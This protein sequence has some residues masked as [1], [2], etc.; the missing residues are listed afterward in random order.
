MKV[1]IDRDGIAEAVR[2]GIITQEQ[3]EQLWQFWGK[4]QDIQLDGNGLRISKFLYYLGALIVITAMGWYVN[5]SWDSLGGLGLFVIAAVYAVCF[6]LAAH[7]M[8]AKSPVLSG[9]LIVMAVGTT[10]LGVY[11]IQKALGIWPSGYPGYYHDFYIWVK[12]GWFV[13]EF[14]TVAAGVLSLP[15]ARIP[16]AMAPVAFTLWYLS[17]DIVPLFF[18][19]NGHFIYHMYV[20]VIFG[21]VMMAAAFVMDSRQRVDYSKWLYIFGVLAFW[22][23]IS[24]LKSTSEFSRA[25]Y[26]AVNVLM[27]FCGVLLERRVFIVFG[28]IGTF[29]YIGYLAWSV[30]AN[31]FFFPFAL[32]LVGLGIAYAGWLYHRKQA[33]LARFLYSLLP[34]WVIRNLPQNR[35]LK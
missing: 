12:S 18:P 20:S 22:G 14:A 32:T 34:E 24:L 23:G 19:A 9:L 15:F 30:F 27:M 1:E 5:A 17:M 13:I 25:A 8:R 28:G 29:G 26:C 35:S 2:Q 11:G 33:A 10:P 31:S 7:F 6:I 3:A 16:F 21:L 4:G